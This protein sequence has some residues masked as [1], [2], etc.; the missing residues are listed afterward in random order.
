ML[1]PFAL[2][3]V[4][5]APVAGRHARDYYEASAPP[6]GQQS[7]TDLPAAG[8]AARREG[9]PRVV[10]TFTMRS[11]GQGGAQLYPGSIATATPQT[12]TVASPPPELNGFGVQTPDLPAENPVRCTPAHIH[13][14]GAGFALTER[15]TLVRLRC[16]F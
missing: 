14:V 15:Q 13:Q 9:R 1:A 5:P 8:L 16:T 2:R 12:F 6:H 4:L 10:P 7:A 11:I 3:P